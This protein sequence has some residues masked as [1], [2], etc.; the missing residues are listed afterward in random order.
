LAVGISGCV[1]LLGAYSIASEPIAYIAS[2]FYGIYFYMMIPFVLA[3]A[4]SGIIF[5]VR[6]KQSKIAWAL[7][8][9][10]ITL[11]ASYIGGFQAMKA[12]GWVLSE[13]NGSNE[14]VPI[15]PTNPR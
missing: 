2:M 3:F 15:P 9:I 13:T 1:G 14:M 11:P 5:A 6:F 4:I 8:L 12:A 10:A 7:F